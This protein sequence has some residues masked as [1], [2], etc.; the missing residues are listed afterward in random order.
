LLIGFVRR[1]RFTSGFAVLTFGSWKSSA[2]EESGKTMRR[3]KESLSF[4]GALSADEAATTE[5]TYGGES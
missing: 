2:P 3:R 5:Q 4:F 1:R